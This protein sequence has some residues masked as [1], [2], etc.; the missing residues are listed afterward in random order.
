[1]FY[2]KK[3]KDFRRKGQLDEYIGDFSQVLLRRDWPDR[4]EKS[5]I[6]ARQSKEKARVGS[7]HSLPANTS[8]E[9]HSSG[10]CREIPKFLLVVLNFEWFLKTPRPSQVPPVRTWFPQPTGDKVAFVTMRD[11]EPASLHHNQM[12]SYCETLSVTIAGLALVFLHIR[13]NLSRFRDFCSHKIFQIFL[14]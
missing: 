11:F 3:K 9:C 2:K 1:M 14:N 13:T 5:L 8:S 6:D 4:I 12:A 10:I 7:I